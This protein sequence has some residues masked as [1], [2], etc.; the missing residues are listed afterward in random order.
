MERKGYCRIGTMKEYFDNYPVLQKDLPEKIL[1]YLYSQAYILDYHYGSSRD[2]E[3]D[4]GGFGVVIPKSDKDAKKAYREVVMKYSIQEQMYEYF[5]I[6][7]VNGT[8]WAE[9]LYLMNNDYG[10][11]LVYRKGVEA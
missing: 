7:T 11:I 6:V 9:A 10:I 2:I 1:N 3:K 5:D 4:M 8:D